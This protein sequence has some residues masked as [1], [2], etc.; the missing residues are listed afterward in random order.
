M[1]VYLAPG[2]VVAEVGGGGVEDCAGVEGWE[3]GR[4]EGLGLRAWDGGGGCGGS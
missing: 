3:V 4:G 1:A 2:E